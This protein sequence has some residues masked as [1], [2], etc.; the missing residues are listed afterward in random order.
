MRNLLQRIGLCTI[1]LVVVAGQSSAQTYIKAK[2]KV[3]YDYQ[4]RMN[5]YAKEFHRFW[6]VYNDK[7]VAAS[8]S[9]PDFIDVTSERDIAMNL[10]ETAIRT[11]VNLGAVIELLFVYERITKN[12]DRM[13]VKPAIE[14]SVHRYANHTGLN[15][16]LVNECLA[17]TKDTA[18]AASA[19][20]LKKDFL[21]IKTLLESIDIP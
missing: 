6:E 14:D 19:T 5:N 17:N 18:I 16:D 9:F 21:E 2:E 3:C 10:D 11:I 20:R 8:V 13:A 7:A 15:I 4:I 12:A 1:F